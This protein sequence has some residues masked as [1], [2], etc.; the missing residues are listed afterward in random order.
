MIDL[1]FKKD[2]EKNL[3]VL[4]KILSNQENF[5]INSQNS[6]LIIGLF[7]NVYRESNPNIERSLYLKICHLEWAYF[8]LL[9]DQLPPK[10]LM[11][12]LKTDPALLALLIQATYKSNKDESEE[13]IDEKKK[14]LGIFYLS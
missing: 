6:Y 5:N 1:Y 12:E 14:K 7:E 13:E 9:I 4:E 8:S 11:E 10:Y 3:I 2:L